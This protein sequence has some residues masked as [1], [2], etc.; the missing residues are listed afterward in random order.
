MV[1]FREAVSII[2]SAK[3]NP[4]EVL[5]LAQFA[6]VLSFAYDVPV[7]PLVRESCHSIKI[8]RARL[9]KRRDW[10]HGQ[11]RYIQRRSF[12]TPSAKPIPVLNDDPGLPWSLP[13]DTVR[14][15]YLFALSKSVPLQN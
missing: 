15:E 5:G 7:P 11:R 1:R 6:K 9:D 4:L 3:R 2:S 12:I 8:V 10:L 14:S 13:D